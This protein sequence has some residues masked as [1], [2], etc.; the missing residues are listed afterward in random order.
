MGKGAFLAPG[1]RDQAA[2]D[3]KNVWIVVRENRRR[4]V[5]RGHHILRGVLAIDALLRELALDLTCDQVLDLRAEGD[6]P[7]WIITGLSRTGGVNALL[8]GFLQRIG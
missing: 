3:H 5:R 7:G 2:G 1:V 8:V 4:S 6:L